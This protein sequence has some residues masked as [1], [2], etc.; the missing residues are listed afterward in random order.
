MANLSPRGLWALTLCTAGA[1]A[2]GVWVAGQVASAA[3]I[4]PGPSLPILLAGLVCVVAAGAGLWPIRGWRGC[5]ADKFAKAA[6]AVAPIRMLSALL[7]G[8]AVFLLLPGEA[9]VVFAVSLGVCY[10]LSLAGET[11]VLVLWVRCR[12]EPSRA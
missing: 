12:S 4:W 8:A 5:G 7:V 3:G 1:T 9:R 11:A 2:L 10:V 6:L